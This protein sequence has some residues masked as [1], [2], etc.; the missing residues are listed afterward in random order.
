M[1]KFIHTPEGVR[2]TYGKECA[3][4]RVLERQIEQLFHT[5]GYQHIETPSFEFFDVFGKEVG[6][7]SSRNLYK[8]FDRDGNTLA[9][10]PDFTPSIA[11][12]A[13]MY[14]AE[15]MMPI[16][17]CYQG[18]VFINNSSYQGRLKESTQ[19]GV[20]FLNEN[21]PEAD[22]E[23]IAMAVSVMKKANLKEFQVSVG[24][25]GFFS[26]LAEEAGI[27]EEQKQELKHLLIIK[28]RFGAQEMVQKLKLREDLAAAF[29]RIPELVGD[30]RMLG[31]AG[32]LTRSPKALEALRRLEQIQDLLA[33]YGCEKYVTFDLG[34]LSPYEYY[35]GIIF[36][37]F[38]YGTGDAVIKGG[39]YDNLLARYGKEAPAVGFTTEVDAL[40]SAL[41]RQRIEIPVENSMTMVLYPDRLEKLAL[42]FAAAHRARG[43]DMAC[44]RFRQGKVLE[45]YRLYGMRNQFGG[46]IYFRSESEVYALN[47]ASGQTD[48]V[49]MSPYLKQ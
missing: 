4:K 2:D 27:S 40:L 14:F 32:S 23:L 46:I 18:S 15:E 8:F 31:A 25:A 43:M 11:R 42:A 19:M 20:E 45:D 28:N 48:R 39:R 30:K 9:L 36:Q 3:R 12:A 47:L 17:L 10:R 24:H 35:T 44:V 16:R 38:T 1:K 37:A 41:E 7:V 26:A 34:M 21:S 33:A 6:T 5:Y 29:D 13:S 22:A 49:D